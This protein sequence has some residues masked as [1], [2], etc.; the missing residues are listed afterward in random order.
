MGPN[1]EDWVKYNQALQG[2]DALEARKGGRLP[3]IDIAG[4]P[5][6]IEIR[7]GEL[8]PISE[9][10]SDGVRL[11]E[12]SRLTYEGK[13]QI[14]FYDKT[15]LAGMADLE[16]ADPDNLLLVKIPADRFLD[17][18][19]HS[20]ATGLPVSAFLEDRGMKMYRVAETVPVT[21]LMLSRAIDKL[22]PRESFEHLFRG[23]QRRLRNETGSRQKAPKQKA[24]KGKRP[25]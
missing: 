15:R 21:Q 5:L 3:I 7:L 18:H 10:L 1:K 13:E 24:G 23:A 17:P 8:R 20:L 12:C 16:D 19:M 4:D 2:Q 22:G 14:F 6:F 11:R 25:G 9:F